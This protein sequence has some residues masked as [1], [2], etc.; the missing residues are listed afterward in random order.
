MI[1]YKRYFCSSVVRSIIR[2]IFISI[3]PSACH[4]E[5]PNC[6]CL[7]KSQTSVPESLATLYFKRQMDSA[8]NFFNDTYWITF[9][10]AGRGMIVCNNE[11]LSGLNEVARY[12]MGEGVPVK[13]K[14]NLHSICGGVPDT[15]T[16]D[17][18]ALTKIEKYE[19]DS[20]LC[21]CNSP[22]RDS[23]SEANLSIGTIRYKHQDDPLDTYYN[24]RFWINYVLPGC[25]ECVYRMI[26][27]NDSALGDFDNLRQTTGSDSVRFAGQI[28]YICIEP[29][30]IADYVYAHISLTKIEKL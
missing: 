27:C 13:F 16:Y 21:G 6:G 26:V 1:Y 18:I 14:G 7:S 23:L 29:I 8:D 12:S 2:I 5:L 28:R 30:H 22:V 9:P 17:L 20:T 11:S 19:Y 24:N 4:E 15:R 3:L 10:N 25:D